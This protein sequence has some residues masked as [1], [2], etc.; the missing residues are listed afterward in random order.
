MIATAVLITRAGAGS[1]KLGRRF[2]AML[3]Y[4]GQNSIAIYLAFFLPMALTRTA[5]IQGGLVP[6]IGLVSL[7]TTLV[8]VV[9]PLMF[10]RVVRHTPLFFLFRRPALM[11]LP[12][13][14]PTVQFQAAE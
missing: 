9:T 12:K 14:R 10:E 1:A 5:L 7:I 3:R 6:N 11:H 2:A 8:A 4:C 13:A